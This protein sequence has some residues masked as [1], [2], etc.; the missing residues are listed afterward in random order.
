MGKLAILDYK[1]TPKPKPPRILPIYLFFDPAGP[2]ILAPIHCQ[3]DGK[4]D[5][6]SFIV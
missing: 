2:T 4:T 1:A 5:N 3:K 6:S